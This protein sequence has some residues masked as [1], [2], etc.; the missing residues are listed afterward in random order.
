MTME[1]GCLCKAVRF[2]LDAEPEFARY[3]WCRDCQYWAAG[4]PTVNVQFPAGSL[5]L[6]GDVSWF[7]N[8]ADSGNAMK[9]G[10]CPKCGTPLF[11]MKASPADPDQAIRVRAGALD[12][13][14]AIEPTATIWANSA[15]HW[16]LLDPQ[17]MTFPKGPY[18]P[19]DNR[20]Y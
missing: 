20:N 8:T 13:P 9:R 4:S 6:E 15:P 5:S 1:G 10:F 14:E 16:A 18:N 11:S 17:I 3:C 19:D 7:Q 2:S 12:D